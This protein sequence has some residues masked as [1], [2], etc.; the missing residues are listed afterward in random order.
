M[1]EEKNV[2]KNSYSENF[3]QIGERNQ[4]EVGRISIFNEPNY[5][6]VSILMG[7]SESYP[8]LN[9]NE[10]YFLQ[11]FFLQ[12]KNI[13]PYLIFFYDESPIIQD[14]YRDIV[15]LKNETNI[16]KVAVTSNDL[17]MK[18]IINDV[19]SKYGLERLPF[20]SQWIVW[21]HYN[22]QDKTNK[23]EHRNFFSTALFRR[24]CPERVYITY[25]LSKNNYINKNNITNV[26]APYSDIDNISELT[27]NKEWILNLA[28][29]YL[30]QIGESIDDFDDY[31]NN[32]KVGEDNTNEGLV[33]VKNTRNIPYDNDSYFW[34]SNESTLRPKSI[35]ITE[36][37]FKPFMWKQIPLV[38]I[39]K[40][41]YQ[42]LN[43]IGF[44]LDFEG[45][46]Y[47]YVYEDDVKKKIKLFAEEVNR[48]SLLS[49]DELKS[50]FINNRERLEHNFKY[51]MTFHHPKFIENIRH[52]TNM[53][54]IDWN[55]DV[56]EV[57]K[58]KK[59]IQKYLDK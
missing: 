33:H 21:N 36:K 18:H 28:K 29:S 37:M 55:F 7:T 44:K 15:F 11:S 34:I 53:A 20:I 13:K 5:F 59:L 23:S 10:Y 14:I 40:R 4:T 46:D 56:D 38:V 49:D 52:Q 51:S 35:F 50:I 47:S 3:R 6:K 41:S 30:N 12:F 16:E 45:I 43:D 32:I 26:F 24:V 17:F 19:S 9:S 54:V 27:R 39:N 22:Y 8:R 57:K 1:I 25:L 31:V 42:F 58:Y 48:L 2:R